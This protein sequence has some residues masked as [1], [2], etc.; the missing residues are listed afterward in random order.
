MKPSVTERPGA[1]PKSANICG[2]EVDLISLAG[3]LGRIDERVEKRVPGYI[4]TPNVDHV[5]LCAKNPEFKWAYDGAFLRVPDGVPLLW[6]SRLLGTPLMER[7]NGTDL[8]YAI[9]ELSAKKG[10]SVFL[11]GAEEG[12]PEQAAKRLQALY[13]GLQIAG[14]H[15]PPMGFEKNPEDNDR[16]MALLHETAPDICFVALGSPK[17]EIWMRRYFEASR[18]P[19]T[20]GVGASFD[21]IAG[22]KRRAPLI[23]Q[24]TGLEWLWRLCT[25]PRRL[26][27]RYLVDDMYF[28]VLLARQFLSKPSEVPVRTEETPNPNREA[29]HSAPPTRVETVT[30]Q[31]Q[32]DGC[33]VI[34]RNEVPRLAACLQSVKPGA[35]LVVYA[36]SGSWDGSPEIA[37]GMGVETVDLD[38]SAPYTAARGRNAGLKQLLESRP[39]AEFVQFVDGDC[40]LLEGWFRQGAEALRQRPDVAAVFGR[41]HESHPGRSVYGRLCDMEWN[42]PLGETGSCGGIAMMRVQALR[43]CGGFDESLI[44]G[45]EPE[46]CFRFREK[47]WKILRIGADMGVHDADITRF[48]QW[49]KRNVRTGH[50]YA[51]CSRKHH[52]SS[53]GLWAHETQSIVFWGVLLPAVTAFST[54]LAGWWSLLFLAAYPTLTARIFRFMSRRGF[55]TGDSALYAFFCTL[56]K[57]PQAWGMLSYHAARIAGRR[58]GLIEYKK[59]QYSKEAALSSQGPCQESD[60]AE[61]GTGVE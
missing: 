60:R 21:F 47:G 10:R 1:G 16:I 61:S 3:M 24:R 12:V 7:L 9:S 4:V 23:M 15:S 55:P 46:L 37:R 25:E 5:C 28:F 53:G 29:E 33:V 57:F 38:A 20:I 49:W 40:E 54:A 32:V 48:G 26:W 39:S 50:A 34:G 43:E 11:L 35:G 36:D 58:R 2:V 6:G 44:A 42:T 56:G 51:E 41:L 45:E 27:R 22:R 8:V 18:V 17:Q 19:L 52:A 13:P 30:G 31:K 59:P 14:M